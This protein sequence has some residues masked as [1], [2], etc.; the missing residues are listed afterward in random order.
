MNGRVIS[1]LWSLF[2][3]GGLL[4]LPRGVAQ[5]ADGAA[6]PGEQSGGGS[7]PPARTQA[8]EQERR[9]RLQ[10]AAE[11]R[12][13]YAAGPEAPAAS[14]ARRREAKNLLLASLLG[15]DALDGQPGAVAR[16]A[17]HDPNLPPQARFEIAMLEDMALRKATTFSSREEW[18]GIREEQARR[19]IAEFAGLPEAYGQLL[20]VVAAS[21]GPHA[22]SLADEIINSPAP[23]SVKEHAWNLRQR[24]T[25]GGKSLAVLI[26]GQPGAEPLLR[27]A[28]GRPVVIYTWQPESARSIE[29]AGALTSALPAGALV[30]GVNL[31]RDVPAALAVAQRLPGE[32]LYGARGYDSPVVRRLALTAPGLLYAAGSDGVM[33]NLSALADPAAALAELK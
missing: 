27:A 25:L 15:P 1:V 3:L 26:E 31:S 14:E 13:E 2:L 4:F 10:A 8:R 32:Q 33:K 30:L 11:A 24:L 7:L 22:V 16:A 28:A 23:A 17:R 9:K 6:S 19:L 18:L 21:S 12:A 20:P 29:R 5:S